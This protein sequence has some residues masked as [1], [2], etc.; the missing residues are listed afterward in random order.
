[1]Y[2]ILYGVTSGT[3]CFNWFLF[4]FFCCSCGAKNTQKPELVESRLKTQDWIEIKKKFTPIFKVPPFISELDL[5]VCLFRYI[6]SC[7]W[8][9][10]NVEVEIRFYEWNESLC[11]RHRMETK[12]R[13]VIAVHRVFASIQLPRVIFRLFV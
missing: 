4:W 13:A 5:L 9:S 6:F 11:N 8:T 10:T 2:N 12:T 1:M 3:V 7:A